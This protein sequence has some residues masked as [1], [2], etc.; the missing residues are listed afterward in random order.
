MCVFYRFFSQK[1]NHDCMFA[2]YF[3]LLNCYEKSL[4]ISF[5]DYV[6]IYDESRSF[7]H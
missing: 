2:M 7:K 1:T 5:T 3:K 4:H 6:F